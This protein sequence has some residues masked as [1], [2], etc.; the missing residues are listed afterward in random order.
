MQSR[1]LKVI[2]RVGTA[3][4]PTDQLLVG[5]QP[6]FGHAYRDDRHG[7]KARK[8]LL[9][10]RIDLIQPMLHTQLLSVTMNKQQIR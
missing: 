7:W 2:R 10:G 9:Y 8:H 3:C 6:S 4:Y 5:E 1:D